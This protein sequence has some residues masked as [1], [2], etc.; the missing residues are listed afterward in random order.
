[1]TCWEKV[2]L[3]TFNRLSKISPA[4]WWGIF[5][6]KKTLFFL[7]INILYSVGCGKRKAEKCQN[8]CA[9]FVG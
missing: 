7:D 3:N 4:G 1:M 9:I 8:L 2:L 6:E 5:Y